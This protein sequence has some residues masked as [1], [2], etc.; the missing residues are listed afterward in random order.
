LRS[1]CLKKT[2]S[3]LNTDAL[4]ESLN[5]Q[6]HEG[7]LLV[8]R[9]R[10][11]RR[12]LACGSRWGK[13]LCASMEACAALL[14]PR[15]HALGWICAP[16]RDLVDRTFMRVVEVL[17]THLAHRILHLDLRTQR[18]LVRNLGGGTSELRG[19]SA[20]MPVTLL[21]EAVDFLIVDEAAK[22]RA[23]V[24]E[25]YL[26]QRLVD[27]R[28]WALFLSTPNGVNWF[29]ALYRRG[30]KKRD[31]AFESWSS[32][33]WT[34]PYIDRASIEA[35]RGRLP[36][37]TFVQEYE[38]VFAGALAEPCDRCCGPA[39]GWGR[40]VII[41]EHEVLATCLECGKYVDERGRTLC[42]RG[43]NGESLCH[44]IQ[45]VGATEEQLARAKELCT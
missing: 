27:R 26:S 41:G 3:R 6:P 2:T 15:D 28:G 17:K 37:E 36:P 12:V 1:K 31:A 30:Q 42:R 45:L 32:P 19:K 25:R 33:S 39:P 43:P 21:G 23:E 22:L 40:N 44:I 7:Q 9:S 29:H 16:T 5:Y 20:D 11:P 8:H 35:E 10:A 18:I 34:N 4:F 13:S 14:E 24:W 38:A